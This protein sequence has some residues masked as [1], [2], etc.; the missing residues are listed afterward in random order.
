MVARTRPT[1]ESSILPGQHEWVYYIELSISSDQPK[2][3]Y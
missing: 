3:L 1:V 2:S